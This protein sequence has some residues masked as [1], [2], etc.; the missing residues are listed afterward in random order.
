MNVIRELID[1]MCD[2][3]LVTCHSK[4]YNFFEI[5]EGIGVYNKSHIVFA[6]IWYHYVIRYVFD[7]WL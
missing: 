7:A 2:E 3:L 6:S 1:T 4:L 5:C